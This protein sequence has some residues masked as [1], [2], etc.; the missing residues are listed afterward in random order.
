MS[1]KLYSTKTLYK[2][3]VKYKSNKFFKTSHTAGLESEFLVGINSRVILKRNIDV[4]R[5][6]ANGSL[7]TVTKLNYN[8]DNSEIL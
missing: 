8:L 3:H 2:L 6:L 5:G 4:E 1:F 7:G